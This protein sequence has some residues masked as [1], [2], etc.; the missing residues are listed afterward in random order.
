MFEA[1]YNKDLATLSCIVLLQGKDV[2]DIFYKK[3]LATQSC[4]AAL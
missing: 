1:F 2:F 3:N 4:I